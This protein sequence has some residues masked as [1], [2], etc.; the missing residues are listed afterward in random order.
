MKLANLIIFFFA[1]TVS[2]F[3]TLSSGL[4]LFKSSVFS[5]T[6]YE[7]INREDITNKQYNKSALKPFKTNKI[8]VVLIG[9]SYSK[10]IFNSVNSST[11]K[12]NFEIST[13]L[14]G[15]ECGNLAIPLDN[16]SHNIP[17]KRLLRCK[18]TG[19]YDDD[20]LQKNLLEADQIWLASSWYP[21][22]VKLLNQS[23]NALKSKYS[24]KVIVFGPKSFGIY[25]FR[26]KLINIEEQDYQISM[27]PNEGD[28]SINDFMKNNL[29]DAEFINLIEIFCPSP[30]MHCKHFQAGHLISHDGAHLTQFGAKFL[31]QKLGKA[32]GVKSKSALK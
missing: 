17:K 27:R 8:K 32:L 13:F 26:D 29:K 1:F 9:D 7:F 3:L 4:T 15:K 23:I 5:K 31:G 16:F 19:W 20:K 28:L 10:D 22:V 2:A 25:N 30:L 6:V 24:A 21:W 18:L 12:D 11:L 14:I